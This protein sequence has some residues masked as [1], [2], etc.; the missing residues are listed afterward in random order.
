MSSEKV[1]TLGPAVVPKRTEV[2][3]VRFH[4]ALLWPG[5]KLGQFETLSTE[6]DSKL[7]LEL[8]TSGIWATYEKQTCFIPVTNV[9][10]AVIK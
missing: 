5:S 8:D 2:T 6:K 10:I 3:F 4:T 9:K 1:T 7:K